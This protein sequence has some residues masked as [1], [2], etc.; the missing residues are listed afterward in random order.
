[1]AQPYLAGS[2]AR[3][4]TQK[5]RKLE[6]VL[7]CWGQ[8]KTLLI[9]S[10]K[11]MLGASLTEARKQHYRAALGGYVRSLRRS[12]TPASGRFYAS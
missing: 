3:R 2:A 11:G 7:T 5:K 6:G 4:S 8:V 1:M 9:L 12:P 10:G